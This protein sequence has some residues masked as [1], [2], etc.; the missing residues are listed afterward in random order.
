MHADE[1]AF[2]DCHVRQ[3]VA[4]SSASRAEVSDC[5]M[6]RSGNGV[7]CV[8]SDLLCQSNIVADCSKRHSSSISEILDK[9]GEREKEEEEEVGLNT[10]VSVRETPGRKVVLRDNLFLRCD[11]GLHV[12]K[13]AAP[14]VRSNV[15]EASTFTGVFG[16]C[17]AKPNLVE[18]T[19][20]ALLKR[21]NLLPKDRRGGLGVLLMLG[22]RGMLGRNKFVDFELAPVMCFA[23]C[24]PLL[25][26]NSFDGVAVDRAKQEA[27][28]TRMRGSFKR[29]LFEKQG[30]KGDS[31]F[32]IVDSRRAE[33]DLKDIILKGIDSTEEKK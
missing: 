11:V 31:E 4:V 24:R 26:D 25:K 27:M 23:S 28:E 29:D 13:D 18:N 2:G 17:G 3:A 1:S 20:L 7:A 10:A 6:F 5:L 9:G 21:P 32:Y 19:F 16:E 14:A 33:G 22:S 15:F 30:S 8:D 12:G